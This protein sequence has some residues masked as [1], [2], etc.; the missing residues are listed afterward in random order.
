MTADD[1]ALL[2][3]RL[4]RR[5][6]LHDP[7]RSCSRRGG[8]GDRGGHR[9]HA[10]G[11]QH[12]RTK[13]SR[14][15][16]RPSRIPNGLRRDIRPLTAVLSIALVACC[17]AVSTASAVPLPILIHDAAERRP[18]RPPST[19][20]ACPAPRGAGAGPIVYRRDAPADG[21]STGSGSP[22]QPAGPRDP[23]HGPPRRRLGARPV[24]SRRLRGG[25]R[26]ALRRG[27][28]RR[29]RPRAPRRAPGRLRRQRLARRPTSTRARATGCGPTPTTRPTAAAPC[30]AR[31]RCGSRRTRLRG[32]ATAGR[33]GG[34]RAGWFPPEQ[35]SPRGPAFQGVRWDDPEAFAR[36]GAA[37]HGAALRRRSAPATGRDRPG[38]RR[39]RAAR[40]G[41]PRG[42]RDAAGERR[43]R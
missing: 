20:P 26:P 32:C 6:Y 16:A 13:A 27:A 4:Y 14:A 33:W 11:A 31:G 3:H 37:V 34:A 38:G 35:S 5:S 9:Y 17:S 29:A 28:L 25:L 21:S 39:R 22:G 42:V 23:A 1:L 36:C 18:R 41:R 2:A 12:S 10:P 40:A 15:R 43:R 24:P 19:A 7:F 30:C 8:S